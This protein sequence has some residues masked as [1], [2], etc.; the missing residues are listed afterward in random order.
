MQTE[1]HS[2]PAF[3]CS[4]SLHMPTGHAAP[5]MHCGG[6]GKTCRQ[7]R[8][9]LPAGSLQYMAETDTKQIIHTPAVTQKQGV[10]R[11]FLSLG[12]PRILRQAG[13]PLDF[14]SEA[15]SGFPWNSPLQAPSP[16][17]LVIF[18][19]VPL[20]SLPGSG[21]AE[22]CGLGWEVEAAV[23]ARRCL[24]LLHR[25]LTW[26]SRAWESGLGHW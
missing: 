25:C 21:R 8:A 9:G 2:A 18:L 5:G 24:R 26:V 3:A 10:E 14:F 1:E 7:D 12:Q 13:A 20:L 23:E 6:D 11:A 16:P 15:P 19:S 22:A 4:C 17:S